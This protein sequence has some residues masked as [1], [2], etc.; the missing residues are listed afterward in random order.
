MNAP[1]LLIG[2]A[3][4][5]A[6]LLFAAQGSGLVHWPASSFMLDQTRWIYYGAGIAAAGIVLMVLAWR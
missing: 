1:L 5:A 2:F 6:G 3:L 4:L